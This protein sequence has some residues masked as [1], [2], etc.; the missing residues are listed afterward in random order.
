MARHVGI[1]HSTVQRIS[2]RNDLKPHVMPP[3]R[4]AFAPK[5]AEYRS[6]ILRTALTTQGWRPGQTVT[7]IS[8]GEA[9]LP[10]FVRAATREP[11]RHV[12]DWSSVHAHAPDRAMLIGL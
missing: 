12:L 7:V 9:A 3:R 5:G 2:I 10:S 8:D 1:S 4:F 6:T 11:V